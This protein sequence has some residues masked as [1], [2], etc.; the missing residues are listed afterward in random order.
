MIINDTYNFV[1]IHIPKCAGTSVRSQLQPFDETDGRFTSRIDEHPELGIIDYVHIPLFILRQYFPVEYEKIRTYSSFA[2]VRDPFGRFPSSLSQYLKKCEDG[3]IQNLKPADISKVIDRVV[4]SLL[5][6]GDAYLPFQYIHFQK[7]IDFI[8]DG[9]DRLVSNIYLIS[10]IHE[11]LADIGNKLDTSFAGQ[12]GNY[13]GRANQ[14]IVYRNALVR[15]VAE[16]T[17]PVLK[18][19]LGPESRK[20]LREKVAGFFFVPR[21]KKLKDIFDSS[22]V[23]DF[24][25]EYYAS[26]I[27]FVNRLNSKRA[28]EA[29][30]DVPMEKDLI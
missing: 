30:T 2:V 12:A 16:S 14:T 5:K 18:S 25:R 21:D 17:K 19:F 24:I 13:G 4:S 9:Q 7:Q 6:H 20:S 10:D 22:Y 3:P 26:D 11:M 8:Y 1:F 28:K 23:Q 15:A 29:D 27:E